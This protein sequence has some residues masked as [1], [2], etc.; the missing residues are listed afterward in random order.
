MDAELARESIK[1]EIRQARRETNQT[2]LAFFL[3][4]GVLAYFSGSA[5]STDSALICFAVLAAALSL[6][7]VLTGMRIDGLRRELQSMP[8]DDGV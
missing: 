6:H 1:D 2:V 4:A 7:R 8:R 3:V 5:I